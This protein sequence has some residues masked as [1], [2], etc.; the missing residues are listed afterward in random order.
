MEVHRA[1]P[2]VSWD[3]PEGHMNQVSDRLELAAGVSRG[4]FPRKLPAGGSPQEFLLPIC[5]VYIRIALTSVSE[6]GLTLYYKFV[7]CSTE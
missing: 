2:L 4:N 7:F 6:S 5:R 3:T 1:E